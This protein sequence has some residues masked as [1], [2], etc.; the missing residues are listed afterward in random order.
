[1]GLLFARPYAP[2]F[3]VGVV[4]LGIVVPIV[5]QSLELGHRIPHTVLPAIL[6]LAGG[7]L[8]RWVLVNAGQ[9]S[10]FVAS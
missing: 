7:F 3:W 4:A 9:A 8:L 2:L 1:V 5:L 6:V 10:H